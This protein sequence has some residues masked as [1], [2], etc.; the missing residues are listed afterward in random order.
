[1]SS[2]EEEF[3]EQFP[4]LASWCD[5]SIPEMVGSL[6]ENGY[7]VYC[8]ESIMKYCLDKQRVRE[9]VVKLFETLILD[10]YAIG[11]PRGEY[12]YKEQINDK[13]FNKLNIKELGL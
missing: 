12:Y 6:Y 3:I 9:A 8:Q 1:M 11:S 4:S 13:V 7:P 10:D 5:A 2:F